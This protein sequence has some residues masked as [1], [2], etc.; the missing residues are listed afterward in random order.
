MKS[1]DN[2]NVLTEDKKREYFGK[3]NIRKEVFKIVFASIST[4]SI[5]TIFFQVY[6]SFARWNKENYYGGIPSN[7]FS[8]D[9]DHAIVGFTLLCLFSLFIYIGNKIFKAQKSRYYIIL[10]VII[11]LLFSILFAFENLLLIDKLFYLFFNIENLNIK[12]IV[13]FIICIGLCIVAFSYLMFSKEISSFL[14]KIKQKWVTGILVM[15]GTF[16]IS[17][18]FIPFIIVTVMGILPGE[19]RLD[20]RYEVFDLVENIDSGK[21]TCQVILG[22]DEYGNFLVVNGEIEIDKNNKNA[23][24]TINTEEYHFTEKTNIIIKKVNFKKVDIK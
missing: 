21:N 13:I 8:V 10:S 22:E 19:N 12:N 6:F 18:T 2:E 9:I 24:L 11:I 17:F 23:K 7:Y 3:E 5:S 15:L 4:I 1:S 14:K 20:T 16:A